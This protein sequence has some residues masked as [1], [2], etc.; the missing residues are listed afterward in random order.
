METDMKSVL[1]HNRDL[2]EHLIPCGSFDESLNHH[3][4]SLRNYKNIINLKQRNR[5]V[6]NKLITLLK[7]LRQILPNG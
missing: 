5:L 2:S 1:L 3:K 4:Q 6:A 7:R